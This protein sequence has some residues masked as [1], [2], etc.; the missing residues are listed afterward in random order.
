MTE[1]QPVLPATM[2]DAMVL[3]NQCM[4]MSLSGNH[5]QILNFMLSRTFVY[6]K[7]T[8]TI[9]MRHFING[10]YGNGTDEV[11]TYPLGISDRALR[12]NIDQL[13]AMGL[14]AKSYKKNWR[15]NP[16]CTY[17]ILYDNWLTFAK[18][19]WAMKKSKL[20]IPKHEKN[21]SACK[22]KEP[23][24]V[25]D[26]NI[27]RI[28]LKSPRSKRPDTPAKMTAH[29]GQNDRSIEEGDIRRRTKKERSTSEQPEKRAAHSIKEAV[30]KNKNKRKVKALAI[31]DT[32]PSYETIRSYWNVLVQDEE[33]DAV[34]AR[35]TQ[36]D[37]GKIKRCLGAV[38]IP[39]PL[40]EF[41]QWSIDNWVNVRKS[42][43]MSWDKKRMTYIP[44]MVLWGW[45]IERFINA[46]HDFEVRAG[47]G[48]HKETMKDRVS[49]LEGLN[50]ELRDDRTTAM[51][52]LRK[53]R[54]HTE[55][56][57]EEI[58][59]LEEIRPRHIPDEE[60]DA[61][62]SEE[63]MLANF[64]KKRKKRKKK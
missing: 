33:R 60:L 47:H 5:T 17:T 21:V 13:V 6:D 25:K 48:K 45:Y 36:N 8:E 20:K 26:E 15:N 29:P 1:R 27:S 52:D 37:R 63:E 2:F 51:D 23:K 30:N 9:P 59:E 7:I 4:S 3:L 11:M 57:Q 38:K 19:Q 40:S 31:D 62:L 64:R 35:A 10:V 28:T 46:Y 53:S 58:E 61:D 24:Q 22:L 14:I 44:D 16:E 18:E 39:L 56:L 42:P 49:E 50:Q 41:M 54:K 34:A 55:I 12:R 43:H 32:N